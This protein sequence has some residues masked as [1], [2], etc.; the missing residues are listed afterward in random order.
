MELYSTNQLKQM[1]REIKK[2]VENTE[3]WTYNAYMKGYNSFKTRISDLNNTNLNLLDI[4][5]VK[6]INRVNKISDHDLEMI[7][8]L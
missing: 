6:L 7:F 1:K 2:L 4:E 5:Q 8:M 3:D